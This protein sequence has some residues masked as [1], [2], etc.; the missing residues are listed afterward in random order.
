MTINF[1]TI[2]PDYFSSIL[3]SSI[4]KRAKEKGVVDYRVINLRDF[5]QDKHQSTDDRPFGGGPG[6]V[7]MI[8]PIDLALKSLKQK[9]GD[10]NKKIIL[11]SAKGVLFNQEKAKNWAELDE[12]SI[13]CGHYEG[14][15]ERVAQYLVDEEVRIGNYV[16]TGGEPAA[17]VMSD[18]VVRLLPGVLGN[19]QSNVDESHSRP[20]LAGENQYTRPAQY[21]NWEVPEVLL[22]GDPKKIEIY[23]NQFRKLASG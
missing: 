7:M 16:L 8:E 3:S 9:K 4:L 18:T 11:T 2:F 21:K 17:A 15:D 5:A 10:E 23:K 19:D 6:M 20:G 14:V 12:L 1:L 22:S 13:I